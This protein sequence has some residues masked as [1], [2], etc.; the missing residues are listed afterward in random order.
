[1]TFQYLDY[2]IVD[3][4]NGLYE[5]T[6]NNYDP[7]QGNNQFELQILDPASIQSLN[8]QLPD[9]TRK[10]I[11]LDSTTSYSI[12]DYN[13]IFATINS[14]IIY[15]AMILLVFTFW[16]DYNVWAPMFDYMQLMMAVFLINVILPP[17]PVYALGCF[18]YALFSFIPNLFTQSLPAAEYDPNVM[19]SNVYSII[20]DFA[21][22][23]N[24]GQ[25]YVILI[26]LVIFLLISFGFSKKFF[27]KSVKSWCKKFI[28]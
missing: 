13:P 11:E 2:T 25:I 1:M 3:Y 10:T 6:L 14:I 24:M 15:L 12:K 8:G 27:N 23:R 7:S 17:T 9:T 21:F 28:R 5:F 22:L 26:A 18:Q 4:G 19:N 20:Q 16:A